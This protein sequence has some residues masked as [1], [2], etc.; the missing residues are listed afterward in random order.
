MLR[1]WRL[2]LAIAVGIGKVL[3][4]LSEQEPKKFDGRWRKSREWSALLSRWGF[5]R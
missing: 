4:W 2:W 3:G 1:Y 5:H